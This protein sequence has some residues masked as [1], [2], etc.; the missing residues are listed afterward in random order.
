M[1]KKKVRYLLKV[2]KFTI[3]RHFTKKGAD[4]A[5]KRCAYRYAKIVRVRKPY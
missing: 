2:G 3:S 4:S 1:A 5:K